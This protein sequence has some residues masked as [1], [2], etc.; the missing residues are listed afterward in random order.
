MK[1]N[2]KEM[3]WTAC[4]GLF[5]FWALTSAYTILSD[6]PV[7]SMSLF[8]WWVAT[9]FLTVVAILAGFLTTNHGNAE[10]SDSFL[11][12]WPK[13]QEFDEEGK[14]SGSIVQDL[15]GK[16]G[17]GREVRGEIPVISNE[18]YRRHCEQRKPYTWEGKRYGELFPGVN[19][20]QTKVRRGV[21][22][23]EKDDP[24]HR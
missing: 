5:P 17:Q 3:L 14:G 18:E 16:M 24:I 11:K 23:T 20:D 13:E 22:G 10:D 19:E 15:D 2:W 1:F 21:N 6:G 8:F 9:G 12:G 4:F 7:D